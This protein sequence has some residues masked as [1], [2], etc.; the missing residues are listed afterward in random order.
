MATIIKYDE[1]GFMGSMVEVRGK[2]V[3]ILAPAAMADRA[4][5]A[6]LRRAFRG[7]G[8]DCSACAQ[9]PVGKAR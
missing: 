1:P 7:Q 6:R 3:C 4:I 9:C 2:I 5:Q 8:V